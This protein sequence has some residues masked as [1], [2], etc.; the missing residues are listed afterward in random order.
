MAASQSILSITSKS[1]IS[2][3][4]RSATNV[5]ANQRLRNQGRVYALTQQDANASN[6]MITGII[7]VSLAYAY[8]LFDPSATHSFVSV[9]FV[10]KHNLESVPLELSCV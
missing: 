5:G 7:Q 4:V 10:K 6:V 2:S 8:V 9:V 1:L 3:K